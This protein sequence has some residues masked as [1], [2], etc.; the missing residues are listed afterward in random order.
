MKGWKM[1]GL[2]RPLTRPLPPK[3]QRIPKFSVHHGF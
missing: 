3:A 1:H 2:D